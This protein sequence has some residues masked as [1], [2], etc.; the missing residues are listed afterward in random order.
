MNKDTSV[1]FHKII[2]AIRGAR[3]MRCGDC[4]GHMGRPC[5]E[6]KKHREEIN[7]KLTKT[8][9][10]PTKRVH[11]DALI[12][13]GLL[14][15]KHR[16]IGGYILLVRKILK[17]EIHK[18]NKCAHYIAAN[19]LIGEAAL[20]PSV[21]VLANSKLQVT[22]TIILPTDKG[23]SNK[24]LVS[25]S[26]A[27]IDLFLWSVLSSATHMERDGNEQPHTCEIVL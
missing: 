24:G 15:P 21:T 6:H 5:V 8:L 3:N 4:L 17:L 10:N 14:D 23:R 26:N 2:H 27:R 11:M 25:W 9:V 19:N 13:R 1:R 16:G 20:S 18:K 7:G 12:D 22:L